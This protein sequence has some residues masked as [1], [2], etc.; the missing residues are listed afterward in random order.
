MRTKLYDIRDD[1]NFPIVNFPFICTGSSIAAASAYRYLSLSVNK[2][3]K[4]IFLSMCDVKVSLTFTSLS[5]VL[6]WQ[7]FYL[8]CSSII[9]NTVKLW[10]VMK[11]GGFGALKSDS[12]HHF[13]RNACTKSG[14]LRFSQFSGVD[15][16]CLFIYLW[17]LTFP[18]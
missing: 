2:N 6:F 13:F 9:I 12:T 14:S 16:F 4:N 3:V 15:W 5:L 11:E 1:F 8:F 10:A 18:L 17:V 7:L